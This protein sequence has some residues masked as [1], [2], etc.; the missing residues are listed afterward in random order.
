MFGCAGQMEP[1]NNSEHAVVGEAMIQGV[2]LSGRRNRV[3][4]G[5]RGSSSWMR[6]RKAR[7]RRWRMSVRRAFR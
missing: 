4:S 3:G 6:R 1:E 5:W 2:Y 7:G